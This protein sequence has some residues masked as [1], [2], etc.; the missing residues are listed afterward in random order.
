[1][2]RVGGIGVGVAV[3]WNIAVLGPIATQ[4]SHRYGV[5]LTT[6][7]LFVT[8]QFVVHMVMQ[9]PGGRA[10]D[11][12]GART[13]ALVGLGLVALG[14]AISL[15]APEPALAFLGRA[16][17]GLGTGFAFVGGSDYIRARGGTPMLQ[18]LYGGGSV[19]APGVAIALVPLLEHNFGWRSAYGSAIAV[20]LIAAVA[21]A[22]APPAGRTV[23]HAGERLE[24]DFFR[25]RVLYRLAAIHAMSFGFSVIVG[26]WVVTLLE[27]QGHSKRMSAIAGSL[28]LL[29]GFFTRVAGGPLLRRP[30]AAR[31]VAASLVCGGAGAVALALPLSLPL[32]VLAAAVVGLAAGTPFARAFTGAALARPESPGAA[33]GFI[34]AWASFVIVAGTPLVGLTFSLPGDGRIGFVALGVL[35][36][37]AALATPR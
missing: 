9:V 23:R 3:G 30:D 2:D 29:L 5:G 37:L 17:V 28:T 13:S 26:N 1:V 32:L 11:R 36:A 24:R 15:P 21:L 34:N 18:G 14:N 16:V 25:D 27:H 33:V 22:A 7:G 12:W 20:S 4:L 10:A 6:V 19:L 8:V 31:W 35:A